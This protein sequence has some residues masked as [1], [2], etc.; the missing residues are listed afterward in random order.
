MLMKSR[1]R[2]PK[3]D[4]VT[5]FSEAHTSLLF[6]MSILDMATSNNMYAEAPTITPIFQIRR[7][8]RIVEQKNFSLPVKSLLSL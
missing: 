1:V 2:W 3:A 4:M 8:A 6:L 5:L 7:K